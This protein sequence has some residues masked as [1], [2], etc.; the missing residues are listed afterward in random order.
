[1]ETKKK[2]LGEIL[3]NIGGTIKSALKTYASYGHRFGEKS[4]EAYTKILDQLPPSNCFNYPFFRSPLNELE[5]YLVLNGLKPA[6][7]FALTGIYCHDKVALRGAALSRKEYEKTLSCELDKLHLPYAVT[8]EISRESTGSYVYNTYIS[9]ATNEKTL[10]SLLKA[11]KRQD[12]EEIGKALGYP[13]DASKAFDKTINAD[14]FYKSIKNAKD[15]G[16][17]IPSWPAYISFVPERFDLVNKSVSKSSEVL[18]KKYREFVRDKNPG[19]AKRV[20]DFF[21]ENA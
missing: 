5:L 11:S 17:Q 21:Y 19:L 1:M 4:K 16:I 13:L 2:T 18:G 12:N 10:K 14:D 6:A 8:R 3:G 7:W 15:A 9:I 20:E